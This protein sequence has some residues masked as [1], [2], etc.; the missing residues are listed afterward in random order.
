MRNLLMLMLSTVAAAALGATLW[1]FLTR[2]R[3]IERNFWGEQRARIDSG[4]PPTAELA[5]GA[6]H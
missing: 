6:E 1:H 4:N 5:D 2:L 3:R